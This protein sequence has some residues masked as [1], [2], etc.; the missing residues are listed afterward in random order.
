MWWS[1]AKH[2]SEVQEFISNACFNICSMLQQLELLLYENQY[3]M[4][5][6]RK[7]GDKLKSSNVAKKGR[8]VNIIPTKKSSWT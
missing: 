2:H 1:G 3:Y 8:C 7:N 4:N 6:S 5:W